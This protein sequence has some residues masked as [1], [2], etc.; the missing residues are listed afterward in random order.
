MRDSARA[1]ARS[2][3]KD[4]LAAKLTAF[5]TRLEAF[6]GT[7][8]AA[9]EGGRLTGEEHLREQLGDL[10]GK[11][12]GYDGRPTNGQIALAGVLEA[13]LRK[14]EADFAAMLAKELPGLNGG[15]RAKK[16][17]TLARESREAWEKRSAES[18]GGSGGLD[19]FRELFGDVDALEHD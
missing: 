7:L 3:G 8:V 12:N 2:L 19:V 18:A 5:A 9:K 17:P 11:V 14:G 13:E 15:L 1:S 16:L 6:R 10:Y 4:G